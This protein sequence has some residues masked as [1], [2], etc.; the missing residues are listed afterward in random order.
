MRKLGMIGGTGPE[1]TIAYYRA[2]LSGVQEVVGTG[3][4]PQLS[5]ESLSVFEV[6]DLCSREDYDA[7]TDYLGSALRRLVA[8]GA[9]VATLTALTPHIVFDRL[10]AD[11]PIPV[12]SA[13]EA[14]RDAALEGGATRLALLGTEYTMTRD[15]FARP[16]RDAGL[17]V[18]TP[19]PGEIA[20]IQDKILHELEHGI[21]V[22]DTRD[23]FTA[24]IRRLR[25]EEGAEQVILGCTELPLL[26]NDGNSP[27]PC[28][29]PVQ[30]HTRALV[31]AITASD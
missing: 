26:L 22:D 31:E 25:D 9:E 6:L 8:A 10:E 27:L 29:D 11:S 3:R 17:D 13:I 7:L 1:S 21:V 16:L 28:L 23:G 19:A 14:T 2:V 20:Y 12:I 15:F 4:L 24:V 5:I 18:F 30:I